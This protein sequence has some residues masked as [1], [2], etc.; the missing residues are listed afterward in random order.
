MGSCSETKY[1]EVYLYYSTWMICFYESCSNGDYHLFWSDST[2]KTWTNNN[3]LCSF[4]KFFI[5]IFFKFRLFPLFLNDAFQKFMEVRLNVDFGYCFENLARASLVL[6]GK[7]FL[8]LHANM[9]WYIVVILTS[10]WLFYFIHKHPNFR[11][12]YTFFL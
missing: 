3:F 1:N 8:S 9:F 12:A 6:W 7:A 5:P 11:S 10:S 4:Q 2:C